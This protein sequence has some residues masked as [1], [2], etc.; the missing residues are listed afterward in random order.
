MGGSLFFA[1]AGYV[2]ER[3]KASLAAR[4]DVKRVLLDFSAVN[5]IDVSAGD[6]LLGLINELQDRGISVAFARVRDAV[7]AGIGYFPR[8]GYRF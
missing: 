1:S 7:R 2:S 6:A 3:L 5:F 4:Q 8:L